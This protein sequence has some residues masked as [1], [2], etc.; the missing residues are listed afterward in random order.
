MTESIW[1]QEVADAGIDLD[2]EDA[3]LADEFR[4]LTRTFEPI[5]DDAATASRVQEIESTRGIVW[6]DTLR[7]PLSGAEVLRA[8][9]LIDAGIDPGSD[10]DFVTEVTA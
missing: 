8:F 2:H 9:A 5:L 4:G 7:P 1:A 6:G 3:I 10:L